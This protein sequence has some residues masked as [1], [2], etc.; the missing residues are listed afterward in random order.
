MHQNSMLYVYRT[1]ADEITDTGWH[2]DWDLLIES[3]VYL[4]SA[5][6]TSIFLNLN[7]IIIAIWKRF[8]ADIDAFLYH[9]L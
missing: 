2:F 3:S 9:K 7:D 4:P 6:L 1:L 5:K 8:A